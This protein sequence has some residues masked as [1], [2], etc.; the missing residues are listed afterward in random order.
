MVGAQLEQPGRRPAK[1][2]SDEPE[3]EAGF[4]W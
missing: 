3:N 2:E 1:K 4:A